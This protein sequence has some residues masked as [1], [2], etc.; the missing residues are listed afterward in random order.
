MKAYLQHE[1]AGDEGVSVDFQVVKQ[2]MFGNLEQKITSFGV[3]STLFVLSGKIG[4]CTRGSSV[5]LTCK[6]PC[7][8]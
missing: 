7:V 1:E 2:L 4:N 5:C 8:G 6:G 3:L